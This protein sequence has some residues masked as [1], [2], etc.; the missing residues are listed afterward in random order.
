M[1]SGVTLRSGYPVHTGATDDVMRESE[2]NEHVNVIHINPD[3]RTCRLPSRHIVMNVE[4]STGQQR[5]IELN[6]L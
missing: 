3:L 6:Q 5:E 2:T 1:R 4:M